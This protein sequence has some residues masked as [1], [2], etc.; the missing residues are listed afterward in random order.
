MTVDT[1]ILI[2][3]TTKKFTAAAIHQLRKFTATTASGPLGRVIGKASGMRYEEYRWRRG[4][5][6]PGV[7]S[8]TFRRDDA[9]VLLRRSGSS[10]PATEWRFDTAGCRFIL[11]RL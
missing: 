1:V 3:S 8:W 10:G 7:E 4:G 9:L 11:K 2:G 5:P 6:V